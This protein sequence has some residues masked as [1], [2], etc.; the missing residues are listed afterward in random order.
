MATE[1]VTHDDMDAFRTEMRGEFAQL[2][3][4]FGELKGQFGELRGEFRELRGELREFKGEVNGR[5]GQL[6]G[7]M[8][9]TVVIGNTLSMIGVAGLVLA[10]V[11][12]G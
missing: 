12:L 2:R 11:K 5:F 1:Y 8:F 4:E 7:K 6:E 3:G 10:A 9:R